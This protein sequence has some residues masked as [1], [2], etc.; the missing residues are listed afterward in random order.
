MSAAVYQGQ[1]RLTVEELPVPEPGPGEVVVEVSYCGI[2]GSDLHMYAEDWGRPG[3]TGG[4]EWSGTIRWVGDDVTEWREGDLV[5]GGPDRGCGSCPRCDEGRV[6]LCLNRPKAGVDHHQGAFAQY[7]KARSRSLY[8]VPEGLD[9]RLAALTEPLAV[10]IH[11]INRS[12]A[13]PGARVLVTGAGPIGL[14]TVAALVVAGVDDVT[15]SE[16][17]DERRA[18]AAQVGARTT[19]TPDELPASPALPMDVVDE[20]FDVAIDCSG[21]SDAMERGLDLLALG[22]TLVLSGTGLRR[23][24]FD[25]NRIILNELVVTGAVE[26]VPGEYDDALALLASGQLPTDLLIEPVDV[27]LA[28]MEEA[29]ARLAAGELPGKVMVVPR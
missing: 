16:P 28:G 6:N 12:G 17:S 21:R 1:R 20:P 23:P 27:P 5:V 18:R 14:L 3:S 25:P 26:Y 10:A 15:V 19:L 2:C 29:V 24:R 22:G 8:R 11:G 7:V 4:H 9:L 13:G